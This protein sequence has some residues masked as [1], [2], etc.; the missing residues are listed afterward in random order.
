MANLRVIKVFN[1]LFYFIAFYRKGCMLWCSF[2]FL[3]SILIVFLVNSLVFCRRN[4]H[5]LQMKYYFLIFAI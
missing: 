5:N 1:F 2:S 4:S 3:L